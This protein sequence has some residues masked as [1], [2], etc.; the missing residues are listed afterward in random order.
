MAFEKSSTTCLCSRKLDPGAWGS[1][2]RWF[3]F[4]PR[5]VTHTPRQLNSTADVG[6]N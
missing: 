5:H 3:S 4:W 1:V 2:E 6:S